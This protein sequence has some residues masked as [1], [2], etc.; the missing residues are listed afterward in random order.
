M[1]KTVQT[2]N[3]VIVHYVGKL[4]DGTVF[5]SSRAKEQPFEFTAG[6]GQ[7]V[8]GFD[9]AVIGMSVGETKT[10]TIPCNEAYGPSNPNS[11]RCAPKAAFEE[12]FDFTK[13]NVVSGQQQGRQFQ[14]II[15]G[16]T[17][18]HVVLDMNHP[19]AD[20]DLTFEIEILNIDD[21]EQSPTEG[22]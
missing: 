11:F 2:N 10:V 16:T 22:E 15:E 4:T 9:K 13:G 19:L 3:K 7:V 5:D 21:T 17:E 20:K 8:V 12:G 1:A 14:A 6:V 18:N